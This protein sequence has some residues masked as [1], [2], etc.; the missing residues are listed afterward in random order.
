MVFNSVT[1]QLLHT[2][3]AEQAEW[4]TDALLRQ[5]QNVS[6]NLSDDRVQHCTMQIIFWDDKQAYTDCLNDSSRHISL[7]ACTRSE[8]VQWDHRPQTD[9]SEC[10]S[11]RW[12]VQWALSDNLQETKIIFYC[13][14]VRIFIT[15]CFL[16][17]EESYSFTKTLSVILRISLYRTDS[18][19]TWLN[20]DW[21]LR[22][23]C[24]WCSF[25]MTVLLTWDATECLYILLKLQQ[26][27][28][29][30]QLKRL[31]TRLLEAFICIEVN[32]TK[33]FIDFVV[34]LLSSEGCMNLLIITDCLSKRIILKLCKN[35]TAEWVTQTFVQHFYQLMSFSLQ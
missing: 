4:E 26:M 21:T 6:M 27:L 8:L 2:I 23:K 11:R 14:K 15:K 18:V 30:Q 20:N 13:L 29:E 12:V 35:M 10:W 34:D 17:D 24:N 19:Y 31:L 7:C 28:Y 1:I 16:S 5:K 3:L 22:K 9:V 25:I 33:I 32:L